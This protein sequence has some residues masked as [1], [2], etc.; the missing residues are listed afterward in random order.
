MKRIMMPFIYGSLAMAAMGS[1]A[2][3]EKVAFDTLSVTATKVERPTKEVPESISVIDSIAIDERQVANISDAINDMPGVFAVSTNGGYDS[4]LIIRGAGLKAPYGVREIMVVRDGVPMTDPDSFSRFDYIDMQDLE[5][6]EVTKGPGSVFATNASGGVIQLIS[7]S[8]FSDLS[9]R[10]KIGV[11][12]FGAKNLHGRV[13]G[14]MSENNY[15]SLTASMRELNNDWRNHNE[16]D[17]QNFSLKHGYKMDEGAKLETEFSY[18]IANMEIPGSMDEVQYAEFE[19]SGKQ[20]DNNSQWKHSARDSKI[21][22]FNTRYEKTV[23]DL[24]MKPRFYANSWDHFHPVTG[25]I[26][27]SKN[28]L[29]YGA[30][31][32]FNLGHN[33]TSDKD[34]LIFGL[35]GR[36]EDNK[37]SKKYTYRDYTATGTGRIT[38]TLSDAKGDLAS[39]ED[40]MNKIYG[41]YLQESIKPVEKVLI[42]MSVRYDTIKFDNDGTDY[43]SYSYPLGKYTVLGTPEAFEMRETYDLLSAKLGVSYGITEQTNIFAVVARANQAPTGSEISTYKETNPGE[44]L[45]AS[46]T[47]NYEVG[48]KHRSQEFSMDFSLYQ[49]KVSDE[50]VGTSI[51]GTT[52]YDNAGETEKNGAELA[53]AYS[54]DSGFNLGATYTYSDYSFVDFTDSNGDYAG[55][56]L[57]YIP[58]EQYTLSAGYMGIS[59]LQARVNTTT[60][61]E[62]YMDNANTEKYKGY[63]LI[64]NVMIGYKMDGHMFQLNVNNLMDTRYAVEVTKDTSGNYDYAAGSPRNMMATYTYTF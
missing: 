43:I 53:L 42:D 49:M 60:W 16:Y 28:N 6:I 7:K 1:D 56:Q 15:L 51:M 44:L 62:Y 4:R 31:L 46:T 23:G 9:D 12:N 17:S 8:V 24:I 13:S 48:V 58:K 14:Q 39:V 33:L 2:A 25:F 32:E 40:S 29:V 47:V 22:F 18:S 19:K 20:T 54:F 45:D 37:N 57:P 52:Y 63:E 36:Q 3:T 61:G 30:D 38:A 50:I 64:T 10:V 59:G 34:M 41:F 21:R 5:R 26:N 55:N 35:A 11:G 27:D